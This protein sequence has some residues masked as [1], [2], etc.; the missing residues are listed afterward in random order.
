MPG[1]RVVC[2]LHEWE[3]SPHYRTPSK[4]DVLI[5]FASE[6]LYIAFEEYPDR[7]GKFLGF[8]YIG[9]APIQDATEMEF[10]ETE[11]AHYEEMTA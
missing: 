9:F 6:G 7:E 4:G 1:D 5:V 10:E 11:S 3:G 2:I 8:N